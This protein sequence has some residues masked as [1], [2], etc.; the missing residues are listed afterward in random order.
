MY[1]KLRN[2]VLEKIDEA[3][4][5]HLNKIIGDVRENPRGFDLLHN[6]EL[7]LYLSLL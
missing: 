2:V 4:T 5:N 6:D 1:C 3:Y 7:I